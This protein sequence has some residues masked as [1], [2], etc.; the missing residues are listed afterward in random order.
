MTDRL[1]PEQR[2][3]LA[4]LWRA[5]KVTNRADRMALTSVIV[6]RAVT[7]PTGLSRDEAAR[8]IARLELLAEAG[9]LAEKTRIWLRAHDSAEQQRL[10]LE[11][12]R[13]QLESVAAGVRYGLCPGCGERRGLHQSG[14]CC[15]CHWQGEAVRADERRWAELAAFEQR[16][17]RERAS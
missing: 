13:E 5:A 9:E 7:S 4:A 3:R 12:R 16:L 11:Q 6:K 2:R 8:V 17:A 14:V 15:T 1:H 10:R